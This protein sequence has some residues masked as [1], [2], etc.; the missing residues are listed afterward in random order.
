MLL[1]RATR[2]AAEAARQAH[3]PSH[4]SSSAQH[5]AASS[6]VELYKKQL[7][8]SIHKET[9]HSYAIILLAT[10]KQELSEGTAT[11]RWNE[12]LKCLEKEHQVFV[13]LHLYFH[14]KSTPDKLKTL[15]QETTPEVCKKIDESGHKVRHMEITIPS[16]WKG[17]DINRHLAE[18]ISIFQSKK[19][20]HYQFDKFTM[21][22]A[23][24]NPSVCEHVLLL[25]HA[26]AKL[27]HSHFHQ[28]AEVT[29]CYGPLTITLD[30][31]ALDQLSEACPGAAQSE[32]V[33]STLR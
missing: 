33:Q 12:L 24:L 17:L 19:W 20:G 2:N 27:Q 1:K 16:A 25:F 13:D 22:I 10:P 3:S 15:L 29:F 14:P 21:R 32:H 8:W 31:S 28:K 23:N 11:K 5:P 7:R 6:Q 4:A 9:E 18:L 30:H 26:I